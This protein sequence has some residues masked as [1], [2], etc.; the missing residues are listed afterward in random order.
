MGATNSYRVGVWVLRLDSLEPLLMITSG[1]FIHQ[2]D[3]SDILEGETLTKTDI[4]LTITSLC[5]HSRSSIFTE[6]L[7][8]I[9]V[10][11]RLANKLLIKIRAS[12]NLN[13][14]KRLLVLYK[15]TGVNFS[16][17]QKFKILKCAQVSLLLSWL[18][19]LSFAICP[20]L[21]DFTMLSNCLVKSFTLLYFF[22]LLLSLVSYLELFSIQLL[23]M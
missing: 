7:L 9:W 20:Y 6:C 12:G 17:N 1:T 8:N 18:E 4:P 14:T 21:Y 5:V 3:D 16:V 19:I 2:I 10:G 11:L 15:Q 13:S 22:H 23:H